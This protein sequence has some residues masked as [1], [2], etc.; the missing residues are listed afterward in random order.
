MR[1]GGSTALKAPIITRAEWPE[2][3]PLSPESFEV[4]SPRIKSVSAQYHGNLLGL[5]RLM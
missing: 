4:F 2:E 3:M 5:H 1:E